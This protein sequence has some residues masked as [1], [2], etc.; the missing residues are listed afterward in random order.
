VHRAVAGHVSLGGPGTGTLPQT[1]PTPANGKTTGRPQFGGIEIGRL[2][3]CLS[4]VS[5]GRRVVLA[6]IARYV[7]KPAT[8]IV[9][10]SLTANVLD[11]AIVGVGC[12]ASAADYIVRTT[13]PAR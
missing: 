5:A 6:E 13:V 2:N 3:G 12:S 11:V 7:G 1:S 8:I 9:L 4:R 10:R